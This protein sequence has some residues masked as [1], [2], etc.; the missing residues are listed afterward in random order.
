MFWKKKDKEE[1]GGKEKGRRG[2]DMLIMRKKGKEKSSA[3]GKKN[4]CNQI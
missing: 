1:R 3:N 2:K 4:T